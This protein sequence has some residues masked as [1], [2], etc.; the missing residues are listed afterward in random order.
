MFTGWL[1]VLVLHYKAAACSAGQPVKWSA[2]S[3]KKKKRVLFTDEEISLFQIY[4]L[5]GLH[6]CSYR[7]A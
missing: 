2:P 1:H 5:V 7:H 6:S 4:F 3:E